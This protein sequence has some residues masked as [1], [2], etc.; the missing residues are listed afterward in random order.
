VRDDPEVVFLA[1]P[2]AARHPAEAA[3]ILP[4]GG[5]GHKLPLLNY[6]PEVRHYSVSQG[7]GVVPTTPA[8]AP[9]GGARRDTSFLCV[10]GKP[11]LSGRT[12]SRRLTRCP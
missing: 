10:P 12:A 7:R 5:V 8:F 1:G 9:D 6:L 11:C 3:A 2:V 4:A